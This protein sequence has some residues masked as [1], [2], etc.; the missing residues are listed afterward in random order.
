MI[1]F[2]KARAK[3]FLGIGNDFMEFTLDTH[4]TTLFVGK[5]G[6]GKSQLLDIICFVLYN[7]TFRD[8]NKPR[9]MNS[10]NKKELVAEVEFKT[11]RHHFLVRRGMKPNIF[12]IIQ[13]G[14]LVNQADKA[15]DY[16][17]FLEKTILKMNYKAFTQTIILGMANF[18]PFMKL[19]AGDRR[20]VIENVLDIGIFSAMNQVLKTMASTNK[21]THENLKRDA[22]IIDVKIAAAERYISD[23]KKNNAELIEAKKAEIETQ[24]KELEETKADIDVSLHNISLAEDKI[25][26]KE[27]VREKKNKLVGLQHQLTEKQSAYQKTHDFFCGA[28]TCPTCKQDI[29]TE[30]AKSKVDE[31]TDKITEY[32]DALAQIEKQLEQVDQRLSDIRQQE[33][34]IRG[35]HLALAQDR[36]SMRAIDSFI[37]KLQKEIIDLSKDAGSVV[38]QQTALDE[39]RVTRADLTLKMDECIVDDSYYEVAANLLK[40]GGVRALIIKKYLPLINKNVNKYLNAMDFHINFNL[41]ENFEESIKSRYRDDFEYGNFSEGQKK[42]IDLALLFT[43]RSVAKLK[44]SIHT[45]LLIFDEVLDSSLDDQGISDFFVLLRLI[46]SSNVFVI[47]HRGDLFQDN[48]NR[49]VEFELVNNF[50]RMRTNDAR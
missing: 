3:N 43:W 7:K 30:F 16:Q 49:V 9:V 46:D 28:E 26:D 19:T 39:Y 12:E 23:M 5:N 50:S 38:E 13:D 20:S 14:E 34:S 37:T 4:Q 36:T 29:D 48:F 24:L 45:N 17:E 11:D 8:I 22:A 1:L 27:K 41:D 44:N 40:D 6:A 21:K 15:L 33:E 18:T 25:K 2:I 42:R 32:S 31:S 10:V 35:H 47:S